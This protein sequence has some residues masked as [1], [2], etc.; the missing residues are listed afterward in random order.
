MRLKQEL[1]VR[2]QEP[3]AGLI[4]LTLAGD[5]GR[6]SPSRL[7]R[8]HRR[9]GIEVFRWRGDGRA[10]E[11]GRGGLWILFQAVH[12]R[13]RRTPG[14][15]SGRLGDRDVCRCRRRPGRNRT[16]QPMD[17]PFPRGH[18]RR[19]GG[20]RDRPSGGG[21]GRTVHPGAGLVGAPK[22]RRICRRLGPSVFFPW[23]SA[24][25]FSSPMEVICRGPSRFPRPPVS[26]PWAIR[27]LRSWRGWL[28]SPPFSRCRAI[29]PQG[30]NW[31]SS[32]FRKFS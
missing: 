9:L 4:R 30:P 25:H 18:Y 13:A 10:M 29:P 26:S 27:S 20:L 32:R 1:T 7:L 19:V 3:E 2:T 8:G 24:W 14:M 23:A 15:A 16:R 17:D 31:H 12:F 22:T 11:R 6:G 28:F 5:I 21:C